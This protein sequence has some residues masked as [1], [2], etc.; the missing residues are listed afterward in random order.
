MNRSRSVLAAVYNEN[1]LR[2]DWHAREPDEETCNQIVHVK[3][4]REV[5]RLQQK[6]AHLEGQMAVAD[7][8]PDEL[9]DLQE[10]VMDVDDEIEMS[11]VNEEHDPNMLNDDLEYEVFSSGIGSHS[12]SLSNANDENERFEDSIASEVDDSHG[13]SS[14]NHYGLFGHAASNEK[15]HGNNDN[16]SADEECD[17]N[18]HNDNLEYDGSSS[19]DGFST[20]NNSLSNANSEKEHSTSSITGATGNQHDNTSTGTNGSIDHGAQN[21]QPFATA[22]HNTSSIFDSVAGFTYFDLDVSIKII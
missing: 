17:P 10:S 8:D 6:I 1:L 21:T 14:V 20:N 3:L 5:G 4:E 19:R 22:D 15:S 12:N 18:V 13:N 7:L 16:S 9:E 2:Y 11:Q